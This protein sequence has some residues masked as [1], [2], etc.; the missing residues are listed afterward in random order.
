MKGQLTLFR[1]E[2]HA[3]GTVAQTRAETATACGGTHYDM[4]DDTDLFTLFEKTFLETLKQEPLAELRVTYEVL[5]TKFGPTLYQLAPSAQ[6]T[7]DPA[8][9]RW[10]TP[11]AQDAKNATMPVSQ[12]K[13]HNGSIP[14]VLAR[15]GFTG[16][17]LNPRFYES[18][19]MFPIGWTELEPVETQSSRKSPK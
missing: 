2:I 5:D 15:M 11:T 16:W 13:R 9:G 8:L 14:C 19:M 1:P 18:L 17:V 7:I 10:P 4:S 12:A 6:R 3:N